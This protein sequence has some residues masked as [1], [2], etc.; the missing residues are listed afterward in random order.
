MRDIRYK[1]IV[2]VGI[3]EHRADRPQHYT[4]D[5]IRVSNR[6]WP[7]D[8]A[9]EARTLRDGQRWRPLVPQDVEADRAV[10]VDI[11]VVDLG[12]EADLGR[13]EGVVGRER[14]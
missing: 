3:S 2:G 9:C 7:S 6:R 10:R 5:D 8:I 14:D 1:R 4:E 13:L 11:R 12:R